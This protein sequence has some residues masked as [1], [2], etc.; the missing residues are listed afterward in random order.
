ML[1]PSLTQAL[2]QLQHSYCCLNLGA[3][4]HCHYH[5]A[6]ASMG[7]TTAV[8]CLGVGIV[9][10]CTAACL[11]LYCRLYIDGVQLVRKG[12]QQ[13]YQGNF[14][15]QCAAVGVAGAHEAQQ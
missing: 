6:A 8:S 1:A 3:S 9:L 2:I 7:M 10:A 5:E 13:L 11:H 15:Q 12:R 4:M 14:L